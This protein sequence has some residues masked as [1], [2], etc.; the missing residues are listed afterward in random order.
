MT[1]ETDGGP[2]RVAG[3]D[4]DRVVQT[5]NAYLAT[6]AWS[7]TRD[8]GEPLDDAGLEFSDEAVFDARTEVADFLT[9]NAEVIAEAKQAR[10]GYTDTDVAHDFALTR[11]RHG[12]GFWDRGLGEIR[13]R[14][15]ESAHAWG[16]TNPYVD[17]DANHVT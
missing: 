17:H 15:T 16:E 9:A 4:Y 8:D 1:L 6:L 5:T 12:A 7:S 11:N 3:I 13:D 2:I 14:L 10:P